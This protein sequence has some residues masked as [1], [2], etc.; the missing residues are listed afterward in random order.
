MRMSPAITAMGV[1]VVIAVAITL[2]WYQ[3]TGE[4]ISVRDLLNIILVTVTFC[5]F[6]CATVVGLLPRER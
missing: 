1:L 3:N 5:T 4:L 6:A 2:R